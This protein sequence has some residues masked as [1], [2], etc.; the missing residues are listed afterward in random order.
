MSSLLT[1]S[2]VNE[3]AAEVDIDKG[4]TVGPLCRLKWTGSSDG[5]DAGHN[6]CWLWPQEVGVHLEIK[7]YISIHRQEARKAVT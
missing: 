2:L 6:G 3:G 5:R 7:L 4:K 1:T